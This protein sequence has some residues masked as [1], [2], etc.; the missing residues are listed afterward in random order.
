MITADR[1]ESRSRP[2]SDTPERRSSHPHD[3]LWHPAVGSTSVALS[4]APAHE[5]GMPQAAV[6]SPRCLAG[7]WRQCQA[8][9]ADGTPGNGDTDDDRPARF[10]GSGL[11]DQRMIRN[12]VYGKTKWP[13]IV[14]MLDST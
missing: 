3:I 8:D 14:Q 12:K 4:V 2:D 13:A 11:T 1:V 6:E 9:P 7:P 5:L 10:G